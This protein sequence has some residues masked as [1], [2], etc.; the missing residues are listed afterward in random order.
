MKQWM[1]G[2]LAAFVEDGVRETVARRLLPKGFTDDMRGAFQKDRL[3]WS[4]LWS[5]VV[6]GH[7]ARRRGLAGSLNEN[8]PV[9]SHR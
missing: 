8:S 2:P 7:Y 6:L 4:R 5:I 9:D 3:H 1:G